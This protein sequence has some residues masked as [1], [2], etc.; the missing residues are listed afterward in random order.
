MRSETSEKHRPEDML[1]RVIRA[2]QILVKGQVKDSSKIPPD[3]PNSSMDRA[4]NRP[5]K[6]QD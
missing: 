6:T 3:N 4:T 1:L 2:A 5:Q